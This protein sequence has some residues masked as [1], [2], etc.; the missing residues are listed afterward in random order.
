MCPGGTFFRNSIIN[1]ICI[2]MGPMFWSKIIGKG[3]QR[4]SEQY[5][6]AKVHWVFLINQQKRILPRKCHKRW[7]LLVL[8]TKLKL[9]L[10]LL[11]Q[12]LIFSLSGFRGAESGAETPTVRPPPGPCPVWINQVSDNFVKSKYISVFVQART[13]S[14]GPLPPWHTFWIISAF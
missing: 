2:E 5:I 11:R 7:W 4:Q 6:S 3:L 9:P 8:W 1:S 12:S 10:P 14:S 13:I